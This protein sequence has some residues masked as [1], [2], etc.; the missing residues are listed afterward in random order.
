M[1]TEG[2]L[3]QH[4]AGRRGM[5][6]GALLDVAQDYALAYIHNEGLFEF[7]AV[8]K[9]GTALRKVRAGND[10]RFSTDLDFAAQDASVAEHLL[11]TI[12][13]SEYF[14]VRFELA[15]REALRARLIVR[16]PIGDPAIAARIEISLRPLWLPTEVATPIELPVHHG[17][18]FP[19]APIRVPAFEETLAEKLAAWRRRRKLR[20]LYDL[21]FYGRGTLNEALIR[22]LLVVKVWY[23]VVDERLGRSPFDPGEIIAE[24]DLRDIASE[25]IGLLTQPVDAPA[26]LASIRRRYPFVTLLDATEA[27]IAR[28]NPADRYL[29]EQVVT[30]L[31]R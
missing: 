23:D 15:D 8:L 3:G 19:V 4:F 16:T 13:D 5:R 26:W 20:D 11:D 24:F 18:E 30:E 10:G 17:Y 1:I 29:V 25:D 6:D 14:D 28:C 12:D 9:G 31:V 2:Y 21:H 27:Q 22:R 7:G